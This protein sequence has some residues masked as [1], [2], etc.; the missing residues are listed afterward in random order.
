MKILKQS[1][2][3]LELDDDEEVRILHGA[4][5]AYRREISKSKIIPKDIKKQKKQKIVE[6]IELVDLLV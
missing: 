2:V 6:L 3:V 4:L 1:P 5:Y